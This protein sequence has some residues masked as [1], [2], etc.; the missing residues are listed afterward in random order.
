MGE[1]P[2]IKA[3]SILKSS[4]KTRGYKHEKAK[5]TQIY[6]LSEGGSLENP[7]FWKKLTQKMYISEDELTQK[8]P[9]AAL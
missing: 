5:L 6:C 8:I 1:E 7:V 4:T 3:C 2:I 9:F